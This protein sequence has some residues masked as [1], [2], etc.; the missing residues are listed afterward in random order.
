MAELKSGG[1][2]LILD[3]CTQEEIGRCVTTEMLCEPG[4]IIMTP[5]GH[6]AKVPSESCWMV[7]GN[8][9][10]GGTLGGKISHIHGWAF[11]PPDLLMPIDGDDL[12]HEGERQKELT[13]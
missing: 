8:V 1:M 11:Y 7:T 6:L 2:A 10:A 5:S 13:I 4:T 3:S 12:K 9:S